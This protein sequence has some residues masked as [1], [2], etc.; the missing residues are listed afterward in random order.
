MQK[1][2]WFSLCLILVLCLVIT[3]CESTPTAPDESM[4]I[5][6][7]STATDISERANTPSLTPEPTAVPTITPMPAVT[8]IPL[9]QQ[10]A[11][12]DSFCQVDWPGVLSR[13]FTDEYRNTIDTTY[14]YANTKGGELEVH[15]GVEFPN[16]FG[17]PILAVADGSVVFAGNDDL[18]LLGP[19]TGFYGNVVILQHADLYQGRDIFSLYAHLSELGVEEGDQLQAGDILGQVGASGAADGSHLHFEVRIDTYDYDRTLNP[20][21]WFTPAVGQNGQQS[22]I[23]AGRILDAYGKPLS[24]FEFVLEKLGENDSE[25]DRYYPLTYVHYGVNSHPLLDEN[26]VLPDIPPGEYRL[27]FIAGRFYELT[28]TLEPGALGFIELQL[29]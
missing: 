29:D 9:A 6:K 4:L 20:V 19:Y 21:L 13:P 25:I 24:E 22:A 14:P 5:T 10:L 2:K 3:S 18:T 16:A 28:F 27:V 23:L 17:T 26:F 8:D 11:C 12:G 1:V 15:H 7:S